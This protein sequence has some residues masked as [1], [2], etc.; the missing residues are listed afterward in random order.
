MKQR[1][2]YLDHSATTPLDPEVLEA[3]LPWLREHFGNASSLH[4]W[5]RRARV[6]VEEAREEIATLIGAHPAELVFTSG[7]TESNN[8]ILKSCCTESGLADTVVYSAVEHHAVIHPAEALAAQGFRTAVLPVDSWGR[9]VLEEV[10]RWNHPRTLISVMH[11]NNETGVIQPLEEIRRLAPD[12]L[13]HTDAVQSLGK[14]PFN[15]RQLGVDF[16]SFS[17][18]KL[19]GP[20]GIGAMYIRRGIEFKAHQ[21]GGSQERNRRAGTEPVALIVGFQ[22]AVR[23]AVQELEH[24]SQRMRHLSD[25]LRR[26]LRERISGVIFNTPEEGSLPNIVNITFTDAHKLDGDALILGMDLHGV[27]VSNGS[28]CTAGSMQPSH[29]LLAMGRSPAQARAAIRFS[30][31]HETTEEE[32]SYA[33]EALQ[34]VLAPMRD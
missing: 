11:A 29:V 14:T 22:V 10:A 17:A 8:A 19:H 15:V 1:S 12:A 16:A 24:R 13:L 23:K 3:M 4:T 5:G 6:A 34:R 26:L 2:V 28:A 7:G 31:S 9:V 33:V 30:L 18:H 32:I 21:H 25:L 27:A 20:K